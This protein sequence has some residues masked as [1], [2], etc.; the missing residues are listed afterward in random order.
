M[1]FSATELDADSFTRNVSVDEGRT[2]RQ[3]GGWE[4]RRRIHALI[5]KN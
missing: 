3:G 4:D 5:R 1:V 2:R